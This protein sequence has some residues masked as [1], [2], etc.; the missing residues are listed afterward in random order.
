MKSHSSDTPY[1]CQVCGTKFAY[2]WSWQQHERGHLGLKPFLCNVCGKS[3]TQACTLRSH[4][5]IH[6]RDAGKLTADDGQDPAVDGVAGVSSSLAANG[7]EGVRRKKHANKNKKST[8]SLPPPAVAP[9]IAPAPTAMVIPSLV[10]RQQPQQLMQDTTATSSHM[11]MEPLALPLLA[12][13]GNNLMHS[14]PPY[15]YQTM[16]QAALLPPMEYASMI[17]HHMAEQ[18]HHLSLPDAHL[19][20]DYS[21]NRFGHPY[22]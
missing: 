20:T 7:S 18:Y 12:N 17:P 6:E 3:F 16:T 14:A 8:S 22:E 2:R 11:I 5:K 4:Q 9:S 15:A 21:R 13:R 10:D 1:E 19:Y